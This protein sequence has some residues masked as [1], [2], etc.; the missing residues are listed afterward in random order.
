MFKVMIIK[1]AFNNSNNYNISNNN[2]KK[3]CNKNY[4]ICN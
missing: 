4:K 1:V 2:H 3:N